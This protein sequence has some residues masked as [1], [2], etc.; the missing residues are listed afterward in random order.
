MSKAKT[1]EDF[2]AAHDPNVIVPSKI[3]AGL[4]AI[5]KEGPE[6]WDYEVDFLRRTGLSVTQLATFRDQFAKYIVEAPATHGK[7]VK[8]CYFGDAK[9]AAKLRGV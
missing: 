3:Q 9:V 7:T 6:N 4:A 1:L 5:L 8:R 2:R